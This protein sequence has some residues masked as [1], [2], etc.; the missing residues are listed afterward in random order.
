MPCAHAPRFAYRRLA[1]DRPLLAA[2][3]L[4]R[5]RA[6]SAPVAQLDRALPSEGRGQGFESLRVRHFSLH[7]KFLQG[8]CVGLS[9]MVLL[10]KHP[11]MVSIRVCHRH[12]IA[13]SPANYKNPQVTDCWVG[14]RAD[15]PRHDSLHCKAGS[16]RGLAPRCV[17]PAGSIFANS[18][19][20]G[21]NAPAICPDRSAGAGHAANALSQKRAPVGRP[22]C[23][24]ARRQCRTR[25]QQKGKAMAS[26]R[27]TAG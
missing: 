19:E 8:H 6:L 10:R 4:A 26:G 22:S 14:A 2:R 9:G 15:A 20:R 23:T 16:D 13:R 24:R 5:G 12:P 3:G 7:F 1:V 11:A 18:G 17:P 21:V 27:G 25:S